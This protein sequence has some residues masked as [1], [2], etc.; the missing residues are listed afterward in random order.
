VDDKSLET[1]L[2]KAKEML[3]SANNANQALL[4]TLS[5]DLRTPLNS[6]LGFASMMEQEIFGPIEN[7]QYREYNTAIY[8]SAREMLDTMDDVLARE[9]F[10]NLASDE[11]DFRQIIDLAPDLICVCENDKIILINPAGANTLG[12][13]PADDLIGKDFRDYIHT[14]SLALIED[15]LESLISEKM[16]LP[17]KIKRPDGVEVDIEMAALRY[18]PDDALLSNSAVMVMGRDVTE[19][20]RTIRTLAGSEEHIRK[21]MDTIVDGIISIDP[22][23]IIET[24]NPAAESIFGYEPGELVGQN[25]KILT[26]PDV[27][28]RHD[29]LVANFVT[30]NKGDTPSGRREVIGVRKDG[31]SVSIDL[32][33]SQ[34]NVGNRQV[35]I[36][37][38]RDI[39][40]RK[41]QEKRL[42]Y[43]ATRDPLTGLPNR[44]L[45]YERLEKT[46]ARHEISGGKFAVMF[47]DLD[48]FKNI[49]DTLGHVVGDSVIIEA[50]NR[51]KAC[52]SKGDTVAHLAGDEFNVILENVEDE[53]K[54]TTV[55][56][57]LLTNLSE[58]YHLDGKEI[59][60]SASI[61]VVVYPDHGKD[62]N[63]LMRNVDTATHFAKAEGRG[64]CQRY[65]EQMSANAHRRMQVETGLRRAMENNEFE[66]LYQPKVNLDGRLLSGCEA[67]LR[68][69]SPELGLVSPVEFIPV[70]EE[71]GLIV[72][73]GD[74]VLEH[75]CI[76][77]AAWPEA[78]H[79]PVSV[80]VNLSALQFLYGDLGQ[81]VSD[82]LERT[83]LD[84]N[85]LDLELTESMLVINPD[86]TIQ[87]LNEL[88]RMG[89]SISMD[90]FGTG[91]SSLSYLTRFPLN[92]LKVDKAF[93]TNLPADM[94][95]VAIARAIVSMAQNLKL[96]I[97]AE[98]IE[99]EPQM[100]FL[101]ALGCQT[102][103]GYLFS[104]PVTKDEFI[105]LIHQGQ[106][107][108]PA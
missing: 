83:G 74:W 3:E 99:T 98:G 62:V 92:S 77:A 44:N 9:Q 1:S 108:A 21:I 40:E 104:K 6:I 42:L 68:W 65:S 94:D 2:S 103:Q 54:I 67:L 17:L 57:N 10:E 56:Q 28:T 60:S 101:H 48:H 4:V 58:V 51:L 7:K 73:L 26:T 86:K 88:S 36:G 91:Y 23:G 49:N 50:G 93:V 59:F 76:A 47:V 24:M 84:P 45:F 100:T 61:G 52:V 79:G 11:K 34:F 89:I 81:R 20:N 15:G 46:T 64:N 38:L 85:R 82:I 41:E 105:K 35:L 96:H 90:D 14:D 13:W 102:G 71:T 95:A 29:E 97:V 12:V 18:E 107:R 43:M 78:A 106:F 87:I 53:D 70:A 69:N 30:Q 22:T 72:A 33:I 39:T 16:R 8:K 25:V 31:S 75:A 66:I 27:A 37:A 80:A 19:R 5:H 55:T 32:A 63:E